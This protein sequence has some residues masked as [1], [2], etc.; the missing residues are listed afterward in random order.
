MKDEISRIDNRETFLN[1]QFPTISHQYKDIKIQLD[2][3]INKNKNLNENLNTCT[4]ELSDITEKLNEIKD[5]HDSQDNSNSDTSPLVKIKA[6]LQ[7]IKSEIQN[8]ELRIGVVSNTLLT[9]KHTAIK[10]SRA[11]MIQKNRQRSMKNIRKP[12]TDYSTDTYDYDE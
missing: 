12:N 4:N 10:S 11:D 1:G 2:E 9:A 6:A 7:Q 8:Y 5:I 3:W